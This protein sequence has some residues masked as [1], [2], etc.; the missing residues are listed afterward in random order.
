[1][2]LNSFSLNSAKT[3]QLRNRTKF[4]ILPIFKKNRIYW[5]K[6]IKV[7]ERKHVVWHTVVNSFTGEVIDSTPKIKWVLESVDN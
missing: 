3:E 1:M 5:L 6:K 7:T 4:P 2:N